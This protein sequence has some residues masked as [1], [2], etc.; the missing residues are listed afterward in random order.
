MRKNYPLLTS[1]AF[2]RFWASDAVSM[3]GTYVTAQALQVLAILTLGASAF[4]LGMLRA[5]QWLPYLLFGLVVGVFVDRYR[6]KPILV[7]TDVIRAV[8]LAAIPVSM[9]ADALTIAG[10]IGIVFAVGLLSLVYEAAHQSFLPSLVPKSL[11]AQANA[12]LEQTSAVAQVG[13]QAL[14]GYLI[15]FAGAPMAILVDAGSYLVSAVLLARVRVD[16]AD[17]S[18]PPGGRSVR[19]ELAE[20][21]RW[22]YHHHALGPLALASHAWFLFTSM[23]SAIYAYFVIREL[24]FDAGAYGATLAIGGVGA[25]V[26]SSGTA[27]IRRNPDTLS[28]MVWIVDAISS[29]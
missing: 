27:R 11:L 6:R 14:A 28:P 8:L 23:V 15:R 4:E 25:I 9:A 2:I 16:E 19:T 1:A 7:G 13:G 24:G 20:G 21:W 12:R 22:V 29:N 10:L 18:P 3:F 26:G 5:A 17:I